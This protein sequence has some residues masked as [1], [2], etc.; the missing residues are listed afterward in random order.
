MHVC[1]Q[2]NKYYNNIIIVTVCMDVHM[3][4]GKYTNN[5]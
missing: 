3:N 2:Y 5:P 1:V 4:A